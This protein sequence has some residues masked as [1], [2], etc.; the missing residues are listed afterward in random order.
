M[1]NKPYLILLISV[2]S[3]SFAAIIIV[4]IN[5]H[6]LSIAFFRLLFTIMIIFP[7]VFFNKKTKNELMNLSTFNLVIMVA[8]GLILAAHFSL[9]ITSLKMTSVASSVILVAIH[10]ILVGPF[11]HFI[12]K[13]KLSIYNLIG[14][15]LSVFGVVILIYGN[16]G[17]SSIRYD[18]VEGNILALLGGVAAG[19]YIIGGRKIRR[20]L[21]VGSY[22]FVVYGVSTLA[23]FFV[24]IIFNAPVYNLSYENYLLILLM[25]IVSGIFGHTFYNWSLKFIRTSIVSVVLL[26]E[27]ILSTIFAFIIPWIN[28]IP[29]IYTII[30][31]IIILIGI[32]MTINRSFIFEDKQKKLKSLFY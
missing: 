26:G 18:S 19:F 27:P 4:S 12:F 5:A 29:S 13:E 25:A 14:I 9:W 31:G 16:Y 32:Y 22:V 11:S 23:L 7:F 1:I 3:V 8:I 20:E 21:S 10:P 28:Q 24:C 15:F 6:P 30:G 17:F 2:I